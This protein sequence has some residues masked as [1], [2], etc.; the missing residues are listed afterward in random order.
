MVRSPELRRP[1][2]RLRDRQQRLVRRVRRQ[3]VVDQ[4]GLKRSV[5][6]IGLY[7]LIAIVFVLDEPASF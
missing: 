2:V 7:V 4:R 1:P 5:G 3:V 6:V